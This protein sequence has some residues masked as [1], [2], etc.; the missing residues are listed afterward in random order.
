M[1]FPSLVAELFHPILCP[2]RAHL[3]FQQFFLKE[4]LNYWNLV[5][6][7]FPF[8]PLSFRKWD[9]V[10]DRCAVLT[11]QEA[12]GI[13]TGRTNKHRASLCHISF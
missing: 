7:S 10:L 11:Q 4:I 5:G 3:T 6:D 9:S 12:V 1:L 13:G 2:G 8:P